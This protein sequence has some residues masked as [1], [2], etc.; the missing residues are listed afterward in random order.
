MSNNEGF[1]FLMS[2]DEESPRDMP[3]TDTVAT[4]A[5][6][7]AELRNNDARSLFQPLGLNSP[8]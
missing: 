5:D 4:S 7:A 6:V 8:Q 1:V 2:E 3:T